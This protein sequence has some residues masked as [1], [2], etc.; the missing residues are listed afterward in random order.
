MGNSHMTGDERRSMYVNERANYLIYMLE[1][2]RPEDT[3]PVSSPGEDD[4]EQPDQDMEPPIQRI[5]FLTHL[6]DAH[7]L[8]L[9]ECLARGD[10]SDAAIIQQCILQILMYANQGREVDL[11]L[12]DFCKDRI[13]G[14][15]A[16]AE[17]RNDEAAAVSYRDFI[18]EID[19]AMNE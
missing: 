4:T 19:E 9:D 17:N 7:K 18:S 3:D 2:R 5:G 11:E 1:Q 12:T 15:L 14:I 10:F 13:R 8:L 16:D 6:S